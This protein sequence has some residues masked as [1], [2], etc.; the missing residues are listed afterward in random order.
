MVGIPA[1]SLPSV[2]WQVGFDAPGSWWEFLPQ[3]LYGFPSKLDLMS[4][5]SSPLP[6]GYCLLTQLV[7]VLIAYFIDF[8]YRIVELIAPVHQNS[9]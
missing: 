6:G 1:S 3:V 9:S 5:N 2:S 8:V 7:L 4:P